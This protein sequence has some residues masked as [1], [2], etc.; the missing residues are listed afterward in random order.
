MSSKHVGNELRLWLIQLNG[1]ILINSVMQHKIINLRGIEVI[2]SHNIH[3]IMKRN[4]CKTKY[5]INKFEGRRVY[6]N[7]NNR[8]NM[9]NKIIEADYFDTTICRYDNKIDD[10]IET[11]MHISKICE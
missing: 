1:D 8:S 7:R 5:C 3:S 6:E 9:C 11:L 2:S 10:I 4:G